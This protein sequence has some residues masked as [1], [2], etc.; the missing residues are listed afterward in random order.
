MRCK[1]C[2]AKRHTCDKCGAEVCPDCGKA[3][4]QPEK[5]VYVPQPYPVWVQPPN[6][7]I[8]AQPFRTYPYIGDVIG[9]GTITATPIE[10]MRVIS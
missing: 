3:H 5:I 7:W 1:E 4:G 9:T 6:Q 2:E 10:G 8:P